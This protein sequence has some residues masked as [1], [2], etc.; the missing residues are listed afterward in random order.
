[1]ADA[2]GGRRVL[3][4]AAFATQLKALLDAASTD[5]VHIS[6]SARLGLPRF[7]KVAKSSSRFAPWRGP[8][9][10]TVRPQGYHASPFFLVISPG[11]W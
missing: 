2:G 9:P 8:H 10:A 3:D 6:C 11:V 5:L 1:M 7:D 4:E